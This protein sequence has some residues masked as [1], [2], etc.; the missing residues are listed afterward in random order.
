MTIV[1][2]QDKG[3]PKRQNGKDCEKL[4]NKIDREKRKGRQSK[5]KVIEATTGRGGKE[6]NTTARG[7]IKC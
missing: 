5:R 7:R 3:K 1:N 2:S 4:E 6:N